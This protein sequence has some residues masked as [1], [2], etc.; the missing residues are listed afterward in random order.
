MVWNRF[1]I[2]GV[3]L[4]LRRVAG[5]LCPLSFLCVKIH[6]LKFLQIKQALLEKQKYDIMRDDGIVI[7]ELLLIEGQL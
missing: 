4:L 5:K 6:L 1:H 3:E 2:R 7:N